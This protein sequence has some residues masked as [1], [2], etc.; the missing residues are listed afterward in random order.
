[1]STFTLRLDKT[2]DGWRNKSELT[3]HF[4]DWDLHY[5]ESGIEARPQPISL[6]WRISI[7]VVFLGI[8]GW[9]ASWLISL[10]LRGALLG[11]HDESTRPVRSS[12]PLAATAAGLLPL[13]FQSD[14]PPHLR[15]SQPAT[16]DIRQMTEEIRQRLS[17]ESRQKLREQQRTRAAQRTREQAKTATWDRV[18]TIL[19]RIGLVP[20]VLFVLA[21]GWIGIRYGVLEAICFPKDRVCIQRQGDEL[22]IRRT[23]V[24]GELVVRRPLAQLAAIQYGFRRIGRRHGGAMPTYHW[25]AILN[26]RDPERLP[27]IEFFIEAQPN[28]PQDDSP[29]HK[30]VQFLQHLKQLT[31]CNV[32]RAAI[33]T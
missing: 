29:P 10:W 16:D 20:A 1:M 6:F 25:L 23:R 15:A 2:K 8:S 13:V 32:Y 4:E 9:L 31:R 24:F 5:T 11:Y 19:I 17:P 33:E 21:F 12:M 14:G 30:L 26:A 22:I 18:V 7:A 27:R 28:A 3:F